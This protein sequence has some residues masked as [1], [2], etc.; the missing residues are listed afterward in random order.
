MFRNSRNARALP[1]ERVSQYDDPAIHT[2]GS[3][4]Q[5]RATTTSHFNKRQR[6]VRI[7]GVVVVVD[8]DSS[9]RGKRR[10]TERCT[11]QVPLHDTSLTAACSP[12]VGIEQR[13]P[14]SVAPFWERTTVV[15]PAE[16]DGS[17][18][19]LDRP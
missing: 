14:A 1:P 8:C 18:C 15:R 16:R 12:S 9:S 3:E 11:E 6:V 10:E 5:P 4:V 19:S 17:F 13:P 2:Q 7:G